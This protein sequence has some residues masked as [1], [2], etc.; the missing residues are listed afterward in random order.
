MHNLLRCYQRRRY[1]TIERPGSTP[2]AYV[3]D[4]WIGKGDPPKLRGPNRPCVGLAGQLREF[5][6]FCAN[7]GRM[8]DGRRSRSNVQFE[9]F[10]LRARYINP[11]PPPWSHSPRLGN[12][13]N[14]RTSLLIT[15]H[16]VCL[17]LPGVLPD[18]SECCPYLATHHSRQCCLL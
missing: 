4:W 12:P 18:D 13:Y 7:C 11:P 9:T 1:P 3:P 14:S 10:G 15:M 8:S 2:L 17:S 5:E 6:L 16:A